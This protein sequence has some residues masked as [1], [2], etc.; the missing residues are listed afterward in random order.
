MSQEWWCG[1][2]ILLALSLGLQKIPMTILNALFRVEFQAEKTNATHGSRRCVPRWY[3][4]VPW[5]FWGIVVTGS[6]AFIVILTSKGLLGSND[7][8]DTGTPC[9]CRGI[10]GSSN[11]E[12]DWLL[13]V[14][15]T[16]LFKWLIYRPVIIFTAVCLH[17][18]AANKV[19][20]TMAA[21]SGS[22]TEGT[23]GSTLGSQSGR[24]MSSQSL[25][26]EEEGR[27]GDRVRLGLEMVH[28]DAVIEDDA[29]T[30]GARHTPNGTLMQ[31]VRS[32]TRLG[33]L[34]S[35]MRSIANPL[36]VAASRRRE[37]EV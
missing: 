2:A 12:A 6:F 1:R 31:L 26:S 30:D 23:T 3:I 5:C 7:L 17:L 33:V 15:M 22:G 35:P 20:R 27:V 10:A 11:T 29:E 32:P 25:E 4:V 9:Q 13:L 36:R 19:A 37:A 8:G 24:S 34:M 16:M 14:C 28:I 18:R 21:K